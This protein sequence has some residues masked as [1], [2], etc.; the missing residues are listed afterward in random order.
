[1]AP[2]AVPSGPSYLLHKNSVLEYFPAHPAC[3]CDVS[4]SCDAYCCCDKECSSTLIYN[5]N[6]YTRCASDGYAIPLCSYYYD[7][8]MHT[9][10]LY[11]GLRLIYT[12]R[13]VLSRS[14]SDC[15]AFRRSTL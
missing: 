9:H 12:V 1:M 7:Q 13:A 10:D 3:F 6:N 14:S 5:W 8:P 11:Q 15:S 4:S 2:P